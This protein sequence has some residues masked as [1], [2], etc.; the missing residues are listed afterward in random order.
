MYNH[1]CHG[2]APGIAYSECALYDFLQVSKDTGWFLG[3]CI[4][5]KCLHPVCLHAL[6]WLPVEGFP[7]I[8]ASDI[9]SPQKHS[10]QVKWYQSV[11]TAEE[12]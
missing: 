4:V 5:T 11:T 1:C 6:I 9:K 3:V 8:V 10:F 12:V 7:F 2:K